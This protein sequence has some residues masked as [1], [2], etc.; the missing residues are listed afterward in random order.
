MAARR[1][2]KA[3]LV[4]SST[5]RAFRALPGASCLLSSWEIILLDTLPYFFFITTLTCNLYTP[6]RCVEWVY[7][8]SALYAVPGFV[9]QAEDL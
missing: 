8:L 2:V 7:T 5:V 9:E 1:R 6:G 4:S 3:L